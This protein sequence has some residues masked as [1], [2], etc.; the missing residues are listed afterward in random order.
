MKKITL[1]LLM[2]SLLLWSCDALTEPENEA[3][4]ISSLTATLN[5]ILPGETTTIICIA[6]DVDND[7]LSYSWQANSGSLSGVG[8]NVIWTA[9]ATSGVYSITCE[10]DDGNDG[11][12]QEVV[13]IYV[14][15]SPQIMFVYADYDQSYYDEALD[16]DIYSPNAEVGGVVFGDPMP[17]FEYLKLGSE[18][19]SG[20]SYRQIYPGY[21]SFGD[22]N[23]AQSVRTTTNL[24]PL[25]VEVSTSLGKLSGTVNLPQPINEIFISHPDFLPLGSA[26]TISWDNSN[27]DFYSVSLEYYK[28]E[29]PDGDYW[30]YFEEY[31]SGNS[32][33]FPGS[34]FIYNGEI[35]YIRVEPWGG[36]LPAEGVAGNMIGSG[37]GYLFYT[38]DGIYDSHNITV[39]SG[40]AAGLLKKPRV[41][42]TEELDKNQHQTNIE[43][44]I[45][46][47]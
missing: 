29:G 36:V 2:L 7:D 12:E 1:I 40:I 25:S 3:P 27:A 46:G 19:F 8:A 22:F 13:W 11:Q 43:R 30:E 28:S 42:R 45:Q 18:T 15:G 23:G 33:T 35:E 16:M 44:I 26:L 5:S 6:S 41:Q 38:A 10:V 17:T 24:D 21:V 14:E 47:N 37:S 32:I 34:Y 20:E 9:P 31:V 39:G 4:V